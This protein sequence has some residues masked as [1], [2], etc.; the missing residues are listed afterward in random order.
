MKQPHY[1]CIMHIV[2]TSLF[3]WRVLVVLVSNFAYA[4]SKTR[5]RFNPHV[6]TGAWTL[7]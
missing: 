5:Y 1:S 4:G 3:I 6:L 7:C 2:A